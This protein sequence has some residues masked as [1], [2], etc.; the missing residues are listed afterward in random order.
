VKKFALALVVLLAA[1][2]AAFAVQKKPPEVE[3]EIDMSP[4]PTDGKFLG[5]AIAKLQGH[6]QPGK[7]FLIWAIGSSYTNKL[8]D[9]SYVIEQLKKRFPNAPEIVY[10]KNVGSAVPYDYIRGWVR[11]FVVFDQPDLVLCYA[12]GEPKYLDEML[13]HLRTHTTADIVIPS[14]HLREA[15]KLDDA[16]INSKHWDEVRKV[17]EK[18]QVEFVENRREWADY[19]KAN[20]LQIKDLL[21]DSVHQNARG[22]RLINMNIVRHFAECK[23]PA[24]KLADRERRHDLTGKT[25]PENVVLEGKWEKTEA[26]LVAREKDARATITFTGNRLDL[27]GVRAEDAGSLR[28]AIDGKPA[29]ETPA[30][31]STIIIP[32]KGNAKPERGNVGDVSPHC[33]DLGKNLVPQTW[34]IRMTSDQGDYELVGSITGNDGTGNNQ[35]PF[36]SKS[37]QISIDPILWRRSKYDK[38]TFSN[39]KGDSWTFDVKHTVLDKVSLRGKPGVAV[40][41]LVQNLANQKH[42]VEIT[43]N[44]DG[45]V[46]LEAFYTF[47]PPLVPTVK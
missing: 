38:N 10:K 15:D 12:L 40:E 37:G 30:F 3:V 29:S 36:T 42:V 6:G 24:H 27:I 2:A 41:P 14:L 31:A 22:A 23:E 17:C 35:K 18:H 46:T 45:P 26:G 5:S 47:T 44:G 9:G 20:N 43:T 34:T 13:T 19:L 11:Q 16:S 39:K 25:L 21:E 1:F 32:A 28:I 33:V 4:R 8:G 7:P